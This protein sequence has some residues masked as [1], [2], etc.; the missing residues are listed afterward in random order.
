MGPLIPR[1]TEAK[2][3]LESRDHRRHGNSKLTPPSAHIYVCHNHGLD[4]HQRL[5]QNPWLPD[6]V[7]QD[8][9]LLHIAFFKQ[10]LVQL[11]SLAF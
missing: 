2:E 5:D 8:S 6:I 9:S 10:A 7:Q 11:A 1:K 3:R 4:Q